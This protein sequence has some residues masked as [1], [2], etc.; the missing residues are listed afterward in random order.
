MDD[1]LFTFQIEDTPI[2]GRSA[3]LGQASIGPILARHDY[4][5]DI[6]SLLGEAVTLAA[7]VGSSLKFDGKLLVQAEGNG[8]VSLLVGEYS[9]NGGLRGYARYDRERVDALRVINKGGR[10]HIP[11]YFGSGLL[12]LIMVYDDRRKSP[13]Q[14][15]VPMHKAT[16]A[17]CAE[18]YFMQ[19]EQVPTRVALT[20]A[21]HKIAGQEQY[22]RSGGM[23]IQKIAGDAARG[24]TDAAWEEAEALFATLTPAEL[25]DPELPADH[26]L[27]R[28]FHERG[29]RAEPTKDMKD[30]CTC[31]AARLKG[32]LSGMP[33]TEL[34]DMAEANGKIG[35]DCQFCGR[36]YDLPL[37]DLSA[38]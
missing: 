6:A 7:L 18:V 28:L 33:K 1:T 20:V 21:E 14:G 24:D 38:P 19:S 31:N 9:T 34:E 3:R 35:I 27:Y 23:L 37:G 30:Q 8:P 22:W 11:Q 10:P 29:V 12:A 15:V 32:L 16:L 25:V 4:P 17:E 2:R 13:Y 26:L 36:H 5:A